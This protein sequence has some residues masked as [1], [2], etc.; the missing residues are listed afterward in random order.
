MVIQGPG[1]TQEGAHAGEAVGADETQALIEG[2]GLGR[3]RHEIHHVRQRARQGF[4]LGGQAQL[5]R[6]ALGIAGAVDAFRLDVERTAHGDLEGQRKAHVVHAAHH[7]IAAADFAV[8]AQF[9]FDGIQ[10]GDVG[11]AIDGF[12]QQAGGAHGGRQRGVVLGAQ[13]DGGTVEGFVTVVTTL[14]EA[15]V[16]Q[17]LAAGGQIV[18]AKD[19][20]IGSNDVHAD[21]LV[22]DSVFR[23]CTE[24]ISAWCGRPGSPPPNRR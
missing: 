5:V 20:G 8:A 2:L 4:A 24:R 11:H 18:H 6:C 21:F 15:I 12:A 19:Q 17:V 23:C 7:A 16:E 13:H 3:I 10:R 22:I 1:R 14:L 9:G